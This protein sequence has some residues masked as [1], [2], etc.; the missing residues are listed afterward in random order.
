ML[1]ACRA[2]GKLATIQQIVLRIEKDEVAFEFDADEDP[3][4]IAGVLKL[5]LRQL[6]LPLFPFPTAE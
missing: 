4:N 3:P 5:Y 1:I 2:L 6:P